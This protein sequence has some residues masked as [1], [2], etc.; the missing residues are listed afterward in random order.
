VRLTDKAVAAIRPKAHRY[1]VWEGAGFGVRVSPRG[2]KSWVWVYHCH[3]R[4]RR[5]T[6]GTYPA[7]SLSDARVKLANA[8]K[9]LDTGND[10]G[11]I[12]VSQRKAER[13]AETVSE[14]VEEYLERYARARKRS[15]FEDERILH[16]DVVPAW[17][18]RK[19]K[20]ISRKDVIALLDG[21]VERG[22]PIQANRTLAVVRRMFSWAVGRDLVPGNPCFAVKPPG[23]ET[24]R[25]RVLSL[26]EISVFWRALKRPDLAMA[27][28]TRLALKLQLVTAQRK[29]EV[30]G[31]EWA[32]F[33]TEGGKVWTIPVEKSKNGLAHR[34]PLSPL[35]LA[36]LKEIKT[37]AGG[38]RWLF[39]SPRGDKPITGPAVDHAMRDNR[40]TLGTQSATPHDL[41]RTAASHM[42]SMGISRLVVSKILN[43]AEPGVTAVYDRH[44]YD[45]EKRQALDA[46][47]ARLQE[48]VGTSGRAGNV[49]RLSARAL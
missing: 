22:A 7:M 33:D 14:L 19:A 49:V 41:R 38:S 48:I 21:I 3:R 5:L 13:L 32:E 1:E 29:G 15:A 45:A 31:A 40:D 4:S 43:H 47:C 6:L 39:P 46:W 28:V 11:L 12:E 20:D 24:R 30:I 25:D 9:L 16:K 35:A 2:V 34:V 37:G 18:H 23:K 8:R 42:T 26:E 17:R 44:S 10:P 36:L 27:P